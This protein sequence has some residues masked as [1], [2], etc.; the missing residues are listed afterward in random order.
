MPQNLIEKIAGR[1][2]TDVE[3][4]AVVHSGDFL[5]IVPR[6]VMTHDNTGAVI[7]KFRTI[8]AKK[9]ANPR[10][11]VFTLD[12]NVQDTGEKNL[13]KYRKIEEFAREMGVDFYPAGRGIG[14]QIMC[15]EGYAWPGTLVVASD[16][17][18]N[19]YGGLGC[20]G[21]PVVRTD[22]AAIWDTGRTWWQIP[23]VVKVN[24][25]GRLRRG[26]S[27][28]DVIIT[29][30]G[31]FNHDEV[32]NHAVEFSGDG[33]KS[34]SIDQRLTIA[35]MTTEWGALA[36]VFPM[37]EAVLEWLRKRAEI[38][39]LR[40]PA[41][42]P[43]D[44]DAG[45]RHP[46]LNAQQLSELE[47]Q[48]HF[49][50]PDEEAFYAKT[51]TLDLSQVRPHVS[52]PNTVKIMSGAEKT[53]RVPVKIDKAYLVSCVNSRVEDL[54]EAAAVLNGRQVAPGVEFYIAAAS[55]E[56]QQQSEAR[57]DWQTLLKAGAIPL[58]PGCGPCIGLG[59]GL[60][61]DGEVGI[62]ATNRNFKGRMGSRNA[63]AY[64]ASPA[65]VA[66]SAVAGQITFP[67]DETQ[68]PL[69]AD[70]QLHE[71][72]DMDLPETRILAGFPSQLEGELLFC[73]QD[74]L[75]TDGIYPG[76]YTYIDDFTAEQQ[77]AVVMENYDPGFGRMAEKGDILAGG[78]NFGTGS[79]REQAAT[80]LKHRGLQL[81]LAGSFSE[82]YK[83]NALNNG[84]LALEA[85]ELAEYLKTK[86]G[87][88]KLTVRTGLR[89]QLDFK[90]SLL[91]TDGKE[92]P[93]S[94]VGTAAQELVIAGGLENWVREQLK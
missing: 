17:H 45:G 83:R 14:H 47:K 80:A 66:A 40:G 72:T 8:G 35:N 55:S 92:F 32:L 87:K 75:N 13:Q 78:F 28:K 91:K 58:P 16:S 82:T 38:V 33:V 6:H 4:G 43:S 90:R 46:R 49:L 73:Y 74:N 29:L 53:N 63:Q 86:F 76:K 65:V 37:D 89:A 93:F 20:L 10:Q 51:I 81:V 77:A 84:F 94:P 5:S 2:A 15:E 9:M 61:Q 23:P 60:L 88:Q 42:V 34:L 79:S 39:N 71:K 64:L 48:M 1:F 12:H 36:G 85:P 3:S 62:S 54:A 57:G 25:K 52:G 22:A 69:K 50:Q 31:F 19:M 26:V 7:P 67:F 21:T 44:E 11:P 68:E 24:L 18:S 59:K 30:C 41:G 70:L 56:V 27:G